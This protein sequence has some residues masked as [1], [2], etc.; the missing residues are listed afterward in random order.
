MLHRKATLP[1]KI[2]LMLAI[3]LG[4]VGLAWA[5]RETIPGMEGHVH[6]GGLPPVYF[7]HT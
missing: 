6:G 4:C 2:L 1:L 7:N 5:G 3:A